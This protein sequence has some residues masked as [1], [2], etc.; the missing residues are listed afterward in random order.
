VLAGLAVAAA[1]PPAAGAAVRSTTT[2]DGA[3]KITWA[4]D[5][6]RGCAAAGV[7]DVGG[8]VIARPTG[9]SSEVSVGGA[10]DER[11]IDDLFD[12]RGPAVVRVLRGPPDAPAGACTDVV[13][14]QLG[15]RAEPRAGGRAEVTLVPFGA[16]RSVAVA[17]RCAGPLASDLAGAM[18]SATV[19]RR[20][21][22]DGVT[23]IDLS[24]SRPFA[25][26]PFSG[27]LE[28]TIVLTRR[29]DRVPDDSEISR[30]V[31]GERPRR[32]RIA[33]FELTYSIARRAGTLVTEFAGVPEPFCLALDACGLTGTHEL[34]LGA[35]RRSG[36]LALYGFGPARAVRGR[37]FRAA[38]AA[39]RAGRLHVDA[40]VR[41]SGGPATGTGTATRGGPAVCSD[42][43]EVDLPEA[44]GAVRRG[45]VVLRLARGEG[46]DAEA[47]PLRT[48]CPGPGAPDLAGGAVARGLIPARR[49]GARR[50]A[51]A[52]RPG[53]AVRGSFAIVRRGEIPLTLRRRSAQVRFV[54]VGAER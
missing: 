22:L 27:E 30:E 54:T 36:T 21:L 31:G 1:G 16:P 47:D 50:L 3:V 6:D 51:L 48:R 34:R 25:A 20:R 23:R 38:L 10:A 28:S 43:V 12:D 8:V 19:E 9:E 15:A 13:L 26:G 29:S 5:P 35:Q 39:V 4:G 7:C 46:F 33:S 45:G 24:G 14:A 40:S 17:G 42:T 18:P 44:R 49:L 41:W 32:R 2:V 11:F 53:P 52:L 37:S